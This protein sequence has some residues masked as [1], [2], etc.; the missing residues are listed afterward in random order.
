MSKP[1]ITGVI[2]AGAISEIYLTNMIRRFP[3][4][5]VKSISSARMES[6]RKKAEQFGL[7]AVT[8]E[9]MLNDPE[10]EMVVVLTPVGSHEGL[11]RRALEHGKHVYT[12]KTLTDSPETAGKLLELADEKG[13]W[14][15]S[16]PDTFLG[17]A[18][19]T[20]RKALDDGLLGEVH[21]FSISATRCNDVLLSMFSFLREPG[22]GILYDYAVY[23]VTALVSLLGPVERAGAMISAPYPTHTGILPDRPEFGKPFDSPNESEVSAIL[24][25]RSGVTGTLHLDAE[26]VNADVAWFTIYGTK[27]MLKLTD[28][29]QFGGDV[30]FYPTET[31]GWKPLAGRK[32]EPVSALSD[33]CRGIGPQE[34]AEAI[35]EG[36][37]NRAGKEMACHALEV[38]SALLEGGRDGAFRSIESTCER[39]APFFGPKADC[40]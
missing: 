14:L 23:Y 24:R 38:L 4:L 1:M 8:V 20:A 15:G 16:A 18:M 2:G 39:P 7:K 3:D 26:T 21:S 36:R 12:E 33:N 37:P 28:P 32:L 31:D 25:M 19:Q 9:E 17:A 11:I 27:G 34:M 13:L 35:R 29:N 6:A 10:I 22:C 30:M 5:E 40:G